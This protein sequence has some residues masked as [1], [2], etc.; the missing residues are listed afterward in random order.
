MATCA[1]YKALHKGIISIGGGGGGAL[2][3][4]YDY[5]TGRISV[6]SGLGLVN[7]ALTFPIQL[8]DSQ[9][10][11]LNNGWYELSETWGPRPTIFTSVF[12]IITD[13]AT[14]VVGGGG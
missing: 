4:R 9:A 7:S 5:M 2:G 1:T 11:S 6:S 8:I 10:N 3:Y 13:T 14:T 12:N